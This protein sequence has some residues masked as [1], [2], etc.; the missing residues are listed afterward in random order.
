M[1]GKIDVR[2]MFVKKLLTENSSKYMKEA[3]DSVNIS[4]LTFS[5]TK[6]WVIWADLKHQTSS[7]FYTKEGAKKQKYN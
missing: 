7:F 4:L 6:Q 3:F 5:Q 1:F 2:I